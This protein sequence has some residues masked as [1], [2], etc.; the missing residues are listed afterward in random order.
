MPHQ[1]DELVID[2]RLRFGQL[3]KNSTLLGLKRREL[4][5]DTLEPFVSAAV[6]NSK[7]IYVLVRTSNPGSRD[8]QGLELS[9]GASVAGHL[10]QRLAAMAQALPA[11]EDGYTCLGAVAGDARAM[12][13]VRAAL[14]R[15]P[16]LVPGYG[17][18]GSAARD[19]VPAFDG[20]GLGAVV[21]ASRTLTYGAEFQQ[22]A[23]FA[24]VGERA[25]AAAVRMRD[26]VE[27]A[28][29]PEIR[30]SAGTT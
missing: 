24:E 1:T 15:S 16:L 25:R 30:A 8:L 13:A 29:A 11:D 23:S 21:S 17:A 7:A 28:L 20:A 9:G 22:A 19:V 12:A 3:S 10:A 26:E 18:Q 5:L 27:V 4:G 14:P 2:L 6:A